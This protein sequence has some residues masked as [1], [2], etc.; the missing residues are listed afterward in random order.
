MNNNTT[1]KY[2]LNNISRMC[3]TVFNSNLKERFEEA[4][5]KLREIRRKEYEKDVFNLLSMGDNFMAFY[6]DKKN[7]VG[8]ISLN[9]IPKYSSEFGF[10]E[11][12]ETTINYDFRIGSDHI[13]SETLLSTVDYDTLKKFS[14][15]AKVVLER[16]EL[17]L[18]R[19]IT[20]ANEFIRQVDKMVAEANGEDD[21][22]E[23]I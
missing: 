4:N 20:K 11:I 6:E 9:G 17:D 22:D 14:E 21:E 23:Y 13:Y 5:A 16:F 10:S 18:S 19:K 8:E 15:C 1:G 7:R 2:D 3:G 12:G